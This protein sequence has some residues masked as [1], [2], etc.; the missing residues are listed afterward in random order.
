MTFAIVQECTITGRKNY[1][2]G[3]YIAGMAGRCPKDLTTS[4][5]A[6]A[7]GEVAVLQEMNRRDVERTKRL[8]NGRVHPCTYTIVEV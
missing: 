4:E 2:F 7:E 6:R 3:N 5:R 8:R 1:V